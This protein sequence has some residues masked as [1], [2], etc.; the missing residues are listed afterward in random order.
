MKRLLIVEDA[1]LNR[2]LL[3][4]ILE[5]RFEL[6]IASDGATGLQMAERERPDLVLLDLS[7]PVVD[8]WEVARRLR[9]SPSTKGLRVIALTA[10]AMRG[11]D[12]R[13]LEAGCDAYLTK[14][15]DEDLLLATI[16]EL[17]GE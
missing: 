12:R 4:Q 13:A 6:I 5:G 2:D 11:D 10:H 9:A 1:E 16:R 3:T 7:L 14:P 8:G 17:I 15:L